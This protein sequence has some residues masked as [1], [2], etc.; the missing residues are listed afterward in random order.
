MPR[1]GRD[2]RSD[3]LRDAE[4]ALQRSEKE[5]KDDIR[6]LW[7][8]LANRDQVVTA[9]RRAYQKLD[10]ECRKA[11]ANT[12]RRL[13][14][15]EKEADAARQATLAKLE[16]AVEEIDIESDVCEFISRHKGADG[17]LVLSS[18][19]LSVLGDLIPFTSST[20]SSTSA[21]S[22]SSSSSLAPS[23]DSSIY[24]SQHYPSSPGPSSSL[25]HYGTSS[26]HGGFGANCTPG[27][28]GGSGGS[29]KRDKERQSIGEN[30]FQSMIASPIAMWVSGG[31]SHSSSVPPDS[32]HTSSLLSTGASGKSNG[33]ART[34]GGLSSHSAASSSS[35][36]GSEGSTNSGSG[37]EEGGSGSRRGRN[38]QPIDQ[39]ANLLTAE[40]SSHMTRLF[41]PTD[42]EEALEQRHKSLRARAIAG[43]KSTARSSATRTME[44]LEAEFE[45]QPGSQ[46]QQQQQQ[47]SRHLIRLDSGS[48]AATL[49]PRSRD[50]E[51]TREA[52]LGGV[53]LDSSKRLGTRLTSST[54]QGQ[55][56][57][58]GTSEGD[59]EDGS[60][61]DGR[62]V[63]DM[64]DRASFTDPLSG[65]V[66]GGT[67]VAEILHEA[68]VVAGSSSTSSSSAAGG[69]RDAGSCSDGAYGTDVGSG[70]ASSSA[71]L[72]ASI[73][74]LSS[75]VETQQGRDCFTTVLNQFRSR[76]VRSTQYCCSRTLFD[77]V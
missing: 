24:G 64:G 53:D 28:G 46:R 7:H 33:G 5:I 52:L 48:I 9:S 36:R 3:R 62:E 67:P 65:E 4:D 12:L 11:L 73:D 35:D 21:S 1:Y 13:I 16:S 41:Y 38:G 40:I 45:V 50:V 37:H 57:S 27:G 76:K 32:S 23:S 54:G 20:A 25:V 75:T 42:S 2:G 58:E 34:G 55:A 70:E 39:S 49:S 51:T 30:A 77:F 15:R 14:A 47:T 63:E 71:S 6:G 19:A 44:D 29:S 8:A 66:T 69:A 26:A 72:V 31:N 61:G 18:Q 74:W 22:S 10:R 59:D 43:R 17:K 60:T 68:T 56:L